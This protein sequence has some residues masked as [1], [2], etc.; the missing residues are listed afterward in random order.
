MNE[1]VKGPNETHQCLTGLF[2]WKPLKANAS[3]I[4]LEC[5]SFQA[6]FTEQCI[7]HSFVFLQKSGPK[8]E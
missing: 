8:K 7:H 5:K 1:L 3:G 4:W 6:C 2:I